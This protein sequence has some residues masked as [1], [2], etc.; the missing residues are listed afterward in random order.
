MKCQRG[1]STVEFV[2]I[3]PWLLLCFLAVVMLALTIFKTH[4]QFY[5]AYQR[6]RA[7]K[8][9]ALARKYFTAGEANRWGYPAQDNWVGGFGEE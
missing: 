8:A 9:Q 2:L 4:R 6:D 7:V 1:T 5:G 3:F